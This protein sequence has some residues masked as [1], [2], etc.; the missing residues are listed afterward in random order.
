MKDS[1]FIELLNLYID[2]QISAEETL[3]LET[4]IQHSP[5]RQAVYRQYCQIHSATKQVYAS[6]RNSPAEPSL[7]EPGRTGVI[8]LFEHRRRRSNWMVYAGGLAAAACLTL[9]FVRNNP[10]EPTDAPLMA[11]KAQPVVATTVASVTSPT[12]VVTPTAEPNPMSLRNATVV[13]PDYTA[14]LAALREQDEERSFSNDR[15]YVNGTQSLFG[16]E[17]FDSMRLLPAQEQRVYRSRQAPNT[18]S[19]A[20]FTAFQFQ[21]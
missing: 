16:D 12:P 17:T 10:V 20:E 19:Q 11:S 15:L 13:T 3:E 8:E 6:F 18:Q 2:R 21:R 5:K 1:R 7:V 9:I 14:M 4:E